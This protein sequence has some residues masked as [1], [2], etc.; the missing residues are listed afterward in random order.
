MVDTPTGPPH[1]PTFSNAEIVFRKVKKKKE[2]KR[3][4][5][6]SPAHI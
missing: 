3:I 1:R 5:N 4:P 2:M 6:F